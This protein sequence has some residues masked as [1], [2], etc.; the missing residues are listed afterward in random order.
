[1]PPK[2]VLYQDNFNYFV[3][4]GGF[5]PPGAVYNDGTRSSPN[6]GPPNPK[7]LLPAVVAPRLADLPAWRDSTT[8]TASYPETNRGHV[9]SN[10]DVFGDEVTVIPGVIGGIGNPVRPSVPA[11]R[12]SGWPRNQ[13]DP[14]QV[15]WPSRWDP[16]PGKVL[17]YTGPSQ[18]FDR[19]FRA[20]P[21]ALPPRGFR[22]AA[23]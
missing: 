7:T 17:V 4:R 21:V 12:I 16:P 11:S 9:S 1:M 6:T 19:P 10:L 3:P 14:Q 5:I 18:Q 13:G 23:R 20:P 22:A 15:L 2:P 8:A